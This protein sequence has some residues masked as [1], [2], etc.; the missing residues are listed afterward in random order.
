MQ[1]EGITLAIHY[2]MS[3]DKLCQSLGVT[4]LELRQFALANNIG[5]NYK[6]F[7]DSLLEEL[8][9][10]RD[11]APEK[12]A[13]RYHINPLTIRRILAGTYIGPVSQPE[14]DILELQ[15]LANQGYNFKEMAVK[16]N[17]TIYYVNKALEKH[18]I[19]TARRKLLANQYDE[20]IDNL[21]LSTKDLAEKYQVSASMISQIKHETVNFIKR[22]PLV[23]ADPALIV[24]LVDQ[25][26]TQTSIA[27][28]LNIAQGTVSRL[29]KEH[30]HD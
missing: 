11:W 21:H 6:V 28:Q 27:K 8:L 12:L 22:K 19:T 18:N 2:G 25:G 24:Q 14:V 16:L 1:A 5:L 7:S 4:H 17:T 26:F 10:H 20:I 29:Y 15:H 30:K 9:S 23:R 13:G 3:E